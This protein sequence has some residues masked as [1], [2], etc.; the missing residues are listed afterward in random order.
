MKAKKIIISLIISLITIGS[1]FSVKLIT[2]AET[3]N[4][5]VSE[6][7]EEDLLYGIGSTSKVFTTAAVMILVDQGKVNLDVPLTKYISEFEMADERYKKITPRML[8][9]HSSGL[10]GSNYN[11]T[12]LLGDND[13]IAYNQLLTNLKSESLKADPGE[14]SVYCNDGFTLAEILIERVS[15]MSFTDFI[16]K[17]ITKPLDMNN[18]ITSQSDTSLYN[19]SKGYSK[20]NNME[21]PTENIS[22][23]GT[24]GIYS[25]AEDL[26]KFSRLFMSDSYNNILSKECVEAVAN[27]DEN[28]TMINYEMNDTNFNYG[29]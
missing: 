24:G 17:Y 27:V 4:K 16:Q 28:K 20:S 2:N 13:R 29:L 5:A 12:F 10:R 11:N 19:F 23:I 22:I 9:N 14:Y 3:V 25:T 6:S 26:C 8:L 21:L 7:A 1:V 18:T 15:G